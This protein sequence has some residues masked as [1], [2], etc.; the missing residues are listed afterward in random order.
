MADSKKATA[1]P[2]TTTAKPKGTTAKVAGNCAWKTAGLF[3]PNKVEDPTLRFCPTH[4]A[5]HD[6]RG[7]AHLA[8]A[9]RPARK[10]P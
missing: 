5:R 6:K 3:C 1:K 10:A 2:T 7:R 9:V 4:A 8:L